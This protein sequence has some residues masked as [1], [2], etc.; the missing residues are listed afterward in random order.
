MTFLSKIHTDRTQGE[1]DRA[2]SAL[3]RLLIFTPATVQKPGNTT[4]G[5]GALV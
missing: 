2:A 4:K 3:R 1:I 5:I